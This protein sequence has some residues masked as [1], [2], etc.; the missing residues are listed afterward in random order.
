MHILGGIGF[1]MREAPDVR[2]ALTNMCQFFHVH[3]S[4]ASVKLAEKNGLAIWSYSITLPSPPDYRQQIDLILGIGLRL[5]RRLTQH[6]WT[7]DLIH[8]EFKQ[9]PESYHLE[10]LMKCPVSYDQEYNALIFDAQILNKKIPKANEELYEILLSHLEQVSAETPDSF[11]ASVRNHIIDGLEDGVFSIDDVA[12]RM[13]LSR[14]A[15]QRLLKREA[16]TYKALLT[17]IRLDMARRYLG[18][19]NISL[20]Q[21]SDMLCYGDLSSFSRAFYQ[22][23][24]FT[25]RQWRH[26]HSPL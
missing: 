23:T 13:S 25:P 4:G 18:N 3:L 8:V 9:L 14:R 17:E 5:I 10:R 26:S 11:V 16:T 22:N 12:D 19:S 24:G 21:I 7:P 1:A 2:T 6:R 15:L 20:T